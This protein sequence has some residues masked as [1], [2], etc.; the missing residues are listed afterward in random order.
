MPI[1]GTSSDKNDSLID[2]VFE[3]NEDLKKV[4]WPVLEDV[5]N[6]FWLKNLVLFLHLICNTLDGCTK[7]DVQSPDFWA[8][9]LLKV[10]M[11]SYAN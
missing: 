5:H 9:K 10:E 6:Y 2:M 8:G 7:F 3:R 11:L 1:D 4:V